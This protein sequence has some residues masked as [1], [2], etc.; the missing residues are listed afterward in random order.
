MGFMLLT[1]R[2]V[3]QRNNYLWNSESL[4]RLALQ[5]YIDILSQENQSIM[6]LYIF[7]H[8]KKLVKQRKL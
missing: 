4:D 5:N 7:Q 3:Q 6:L 2:K 1:Q 8:R